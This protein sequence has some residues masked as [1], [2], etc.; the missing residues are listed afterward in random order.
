MINDILQISKLQKGEGLDKVVEVDLVKIF[1]EIYN[2]YRK[3]MNMKKSGIIS[4]WSQAAE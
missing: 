1:D 2:E 3:L 4:R